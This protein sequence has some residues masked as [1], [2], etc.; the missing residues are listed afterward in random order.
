MV[1]YVASLSIAERRTQLSHKLVAKLMKSKLIN[2]LTASF[3]SSLLSAMLDH[4][5][6]TGQQ[7]LRQRQQGNNYEL[8]EVAGECKERRLSAHEKPVSVMLLWPMHSEKD[9]HR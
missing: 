1:V 8:A 3:L 7:L 9:F 5:P 2:P 6:P 4:P